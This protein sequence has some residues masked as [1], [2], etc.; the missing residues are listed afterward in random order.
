[1]KKFVYSARMTAAA[2]GVASQT[3]GGGRNTG[4]RGSGG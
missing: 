1:M 3:M 2:G 4:V